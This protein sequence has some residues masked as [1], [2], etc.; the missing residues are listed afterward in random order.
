MRRPSARSLLQLRQTDET[1]Q[2][3][4]AELHIWV[5]PP[6]ETPYRPHVILIVDLDNGALMASELTMS[7][8]SPDEVLVVIYNAI[9]QQHQLSRP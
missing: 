7:D 6:D 4:T 1:W 3:A 9:R 2:I 5:T 8:P